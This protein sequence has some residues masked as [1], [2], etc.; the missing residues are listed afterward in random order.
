VRAEGVASATSAPA[1]MKLQTSYDS[2][3]L[4]LILTHRASCCPACWNDMALMGLQH[5]DKIQFQN[6]V[7]KKCKDT[8]QHNK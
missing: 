4:Q 2:N 1:Q 3:R 5:L 6:G 7:R 8:E